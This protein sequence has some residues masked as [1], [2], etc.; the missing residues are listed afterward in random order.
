M[1]EAAKAG[2]G[3]V[4]RGGAAKGGPGKEQGDFWQTWQRSASTTLS[5]A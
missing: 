5:A 3:I 1:S 4:I 2:A